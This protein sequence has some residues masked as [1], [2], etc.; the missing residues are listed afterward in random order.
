MVSPAMIDFSL[1]IA[2][3]SCCEARQVL[4]YGVVFSHP[5][6]LHYKSNQPLLSVFKRLLGV[7]SFWFNNL[8][9]TTS[10]RLRRNLPSVW[11]GTQ[12]MSVGKKATVVNAA[13][14]G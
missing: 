6:E 7:L 1:L 10:N 8:L 2:F 14:G 9:L 4:P 11:L 3:S 12:A 5:I 13:R